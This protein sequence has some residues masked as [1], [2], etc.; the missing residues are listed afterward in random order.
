MPG[1]RWTVPTYRPYV[2]PAQRRPATRSLALAGLACFR[3]AGE[4][5]AGLFRLRQ[6]ST[7]V[8]DSKLTCARHRGKP[9][10]H[11]QPG[12]DLSQEVPNR[13]DRDKLPVVDLLVAASFRHEPYHLDLVSFH[14]AVA[15]NKRVRAMAASCRHTHG[16][17]SSKASIAVSSRLAHARGCYGLC[18]AEANMDSPTTEQRRHDVSRRPVLAGVRRRCAVSG[19]SAYMQSGVR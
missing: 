16:S 15:R 10:V 5:V 13:I 18:P 7:S 17:A 11:A 19:S 12:R 1:A 14:R 6:L 4:R 8:Q 9:R 2:G 3:T